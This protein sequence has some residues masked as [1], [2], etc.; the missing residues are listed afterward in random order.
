MSRHVLLHI[1]AYVILTGSFHLPHTKRDARAEYVAQHII[2]AL[3][4]DIDEVADTS[5]PLP[6][7]LPTA[8]QFMD[9]VGKVC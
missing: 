7:M 8:E 1:F 6:H 5:S 9:Q 3:Y 4:F 2:G